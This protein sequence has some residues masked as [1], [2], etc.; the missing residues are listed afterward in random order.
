MLSTTPFVA[1]AGPQMRGER[2]LTCMRGQVGQELGSSGGADERPPA[3]RALMAHGTGPPG[4]G[5][6]ST[7]QVR[8][9]PGRTE[10]S[11]MA[12]VFLPS[13]IAPALCRTGVGRTR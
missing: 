6:S 12:R 11:L 9:T 2:I 10:Q 7:V 13:F 4:W 5:R 3:V 1:L 8:R